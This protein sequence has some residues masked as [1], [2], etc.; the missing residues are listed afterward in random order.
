MKSLIINF[1][2]GIFVCGCVSVSI[3]EPH[4]CDATVVTFPSATITSTQS[5]TVDVGVS[6][7]YVNQILVLNGQLK[8]G[9]GDED[10]DFGFLDEIMISVVNS[11][12][13]DLVIWDSQQTNS[14]TLQVTA[15][16]K[17]LAKYIDSNNKLTLNITAST[18]TPP[19]L[20][21]DFTASLC[22]SIEADKTY[23]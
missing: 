17:N 16:D 10:G 2:L 3:N 23:E 4:L 7:G 9:D 5:F 21:W 1:L 8:F 15:S 11:N 13:E 18:Q 20:D 22:V 12:G 6:S 14:S 19:N